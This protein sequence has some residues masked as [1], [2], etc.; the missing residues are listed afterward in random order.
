MLE[1]GE[2]IDNNSI[3]KLNYRLYYITKLEKDGR[4]A[5]CHNAESR[6]MTDIK[7]YM[8]ANPFIISEPTR[9]LIHISLNKFDFLI[10]GQDFDLTPLGEIKF[11]K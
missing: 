7:K 4:I 9:P 6:A 5:I 10:E 1:N 8:T 2:Q 11:K 3:E